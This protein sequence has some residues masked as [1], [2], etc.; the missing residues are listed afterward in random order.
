M[1]L[2]SVMAILGLPTNFPS[3]SKYFDTLVGEGETYASPKTEDGKIPH[4]TQACS[5]CPANTSHKQ[6]FKVR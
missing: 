5:R 2:Y 6:L 4:E 1:Q 3:V